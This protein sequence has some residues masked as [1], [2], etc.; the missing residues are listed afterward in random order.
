M[1]K[2][3]FTLILSF[4]FIVL[5]F[6]L[7]SCSN[8]GNIKIGQRAPSFSLPDIENKDVSLADFKGKAILIRFWTVDC[9]ACAKEMPE[10]DEIYKTHKDKGLTI[11]GINVRQPKDVVKRF[12]E[13]HYLSFPI[14]LDTY[15]KISKKYGIHGVP[16]S[17][18]LSK[19]GTV[20]DKIY[21]EIDKETLEGLI[22]K[23]LS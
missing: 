5:S 10:L 9:T 1:K 15:S 20:T 4:I 21:G 7:L 2:N 14:L 13:E 16:V 22:V 6:T 8:E 19:D 11:I 12:T 17:F 3:P 23:Q 18:I